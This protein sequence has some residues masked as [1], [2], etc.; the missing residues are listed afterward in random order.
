M[1]HRIQSSRRSKRTSAL[2]RNLT[3]NASILMRLERR[4]QTLN[5]FGS[6]TQ[7]MTQPMASSTLCQRR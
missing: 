5:I 2:G 1:K 7:S 4:K 6:I 3:K